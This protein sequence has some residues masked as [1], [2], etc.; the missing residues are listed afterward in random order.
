MCQVMCYGNRFCCV[1]VTV[2]VLSCA[3]AVMS[4]AIVMV[5]CVISS[6]YL[7][8]LCLVRKVSR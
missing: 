4:D 7:S 1:S 3:R 6:V 8:E 5:C 2:G